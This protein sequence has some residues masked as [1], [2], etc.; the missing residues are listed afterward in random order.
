VALSGEVRA[1]GRSDLR[2][3]EAQKLGFA[4]AFAP[5]A[6]KGSDGGLKVKRIAHIG[7]LAALI[8]PE[9]EKKR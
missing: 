4:N 8:A 2:L 6:K 5:P 3:K 7:E 1:V 9:P